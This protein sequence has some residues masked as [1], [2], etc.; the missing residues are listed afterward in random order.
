MS[1]KAILTMNRS[2]LARNA[3]AD[4]LRTVVVARAAGSSVVAVTSA[5]W[6]SPLDIAD[7]T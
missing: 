2:R 3:A 7:C 4:T 6:S 1:G 5:S